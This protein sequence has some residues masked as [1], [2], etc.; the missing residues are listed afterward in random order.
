VKK[1]LAV[2]PMF[3]LN[4]AM[5][6]KNWWDHQVFYQ[7]YP[8]SFADSNGDGIGDIPG[9]IQ[10][11]DYLQWLGIDGIWLSPHYPSPLKD[12]GYDISDYTGVAKEYGSLKDF[13]VMIQEAHKR[14]IKILIDLVLNH[15]SDKHPWFQESKSS[16][17]NPKRDWYI[18]RD[19]KNGGPPNNWQSIFWGSSWTKVEKQYY[20]HF[21]LTHQPDLNWRNPEVQ[22]AML[23]VMSYWIDMGVDGFRIDAVNAMFETEDLSDHTSP[24]TAKSLFEEFFYKRD[25]LDDADM[26]HMFNVLFGKQNNQPEIAKIL[27]KIRNLADSRGK[28]FL[29]GESDNLKLLGEKEDGLH[30]IFNF[31]LSRSAAP[32]ASKILEICEKWHELPA[33]ITLNNH[34]QTRIKTVFKKL[35]LPEQSAWLAP[36]LMLTQKPAVFLYYGEEIGMEDNI[37][38][39]VEQMKDRTI[40]MFQKVFKEEGK[41]EE[42]ITKELQI[43]TRD[44]CRTPMQWSQSKY[45]GFSH[46]E[47][48][49][50]I[51]PNYQEGVDVQSQLSDQVSLLHHYKSLIDLRKTNP[52]LQEGSFHSVKIVD[53]ESIV[54]FERRYEEESVFVILHL[55]E[56]PASLGS[57]RQALGAKASSTIEKRGSLMYRAVPE[58]LIWT[59]QMEKEGNGLKDLLRSSLE[60]FETRIIRVS[61]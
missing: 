52:C 33:A 32:K 29:I 30:H 58:K 49:L 27:Q 4:D 8:R 57:L 34:D 5:R 15:T 39:P 13:R 35:Q 60:A 38:I 48:W 25:Q 9:I 55:N 20:Y 14:G 22:E 7:I 1:S 44:R 17:S 12:C 16:K 53:D 26:E 40:E 43:L 21:F 23:R 41:S 51:H 61:G 37:E 45:A 31:E 11:L 6:T 36:S 24:H 18:W 10:Q 56:R 59:G 2:F 46:A 28:I 3:W 42:E 19:G 47:P 50:P 54:C